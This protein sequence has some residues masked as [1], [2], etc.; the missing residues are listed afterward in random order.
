MEIRTERLLLRPWRR[1]DEDA[2]ARNG[3]HREVWRNVGDGFPH[4]YTRE[5][6]E[7]WIASAGADPAPWHLAI[8]AR[9]E[10]VGGIGLYRADGMARFTGQL[11]YWLGPSHWGLGYASE[12]ARAFVAAV[13]ER[14]DVERLEARVFAWNAAS[15]GV[16]QKLGFREEALLRRA[17]FK[18]GQLV[19]EWLYARLRGE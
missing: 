5:A 11:G 1:G 6:A 3:N 9:D 4:P 15:R 12:A 16:L 19:D 10:A 18:D 13:F 7:A 2:L 14:T 8:V 17:A